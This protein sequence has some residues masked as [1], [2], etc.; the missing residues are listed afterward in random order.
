MISLGIPKFSKGIICSKELGHIERE[1]EWKPHTS[2]SFIGRQKLP[3]REDKTGHRDWK[4]L[5]DLG[6]NEIKIIYK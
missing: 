2:R 5:F 6:L 4:R 3:V 1:G